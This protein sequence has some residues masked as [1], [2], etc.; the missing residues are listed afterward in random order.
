MFTIVLPPLNPV[1]LNL[2]YISIRWYALAYIFGLLLG[3]IYSYWLENS[4]NYFKDSKIKRKF[5]EDYITLLALCIIIGGRFGYV[6]FYNFTYYLEN[7]IKI[8][9]IWEGGM[10][11]HGALIVCCLG[12]FIFARKKH[13]N[14][15][16]LADLTTVAA[17]I[18][19]FFGRIANFINQELPGR[20]TEMPWGVLFNNYNLPRHP[21]EIYEALLEGLALFFILFIAWKKFNLYKIPGLISC[22]FLI[23]YGLFRTFIE[24]FRLPDPQIGYIFNYFTLGQIFSVLM[25]VIGMV[26]FIFIK[27]KTNATNSKQ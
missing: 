4:T 20:V 9:Y 18:G 24:F 12:I 7:P 5:F 2:G 6:L 17:P 13:F 1:A 27:T 25:L 22:L 8:I 15:L 19:I 3:V 21:S 23:F 10:S 16:M 14:A 26:I 11:F